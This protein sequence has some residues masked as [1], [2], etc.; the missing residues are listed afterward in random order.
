[1]A[2]RLKAIELACNIPTTIQTQ[3]VKC[4]TCA[5]LTRGL[6][7]LINRVCN[8]LLLLM[9]VAP[10]ALPQPNY[11]EFR[12][13]QACFMKSVRESVQWSKYTHASVLFPV[14]NYGGFARHA[15]IDD[16]RTRQDSY[17]AWHKGKTLHGLVSGKLGP[18]VGLGWYYGTFAEADA[19]QVAGSIIS[20]LWE[21][22]QGKRVQAGLALLGSL[23]LLTKE[24]PAILVADQMGY[25]ANIFGPIPT[26]FGGWGPPKSAYV[27]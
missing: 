13:Q 6:S 1:V 15:D 23:N 16:P 8:A 11:A 27:N 24:Y 19:G 4:A 14:G 2:I 9:G 5:T 22:A 26:S 17:S 7:V 25:T 20:S 12:E 18:G 21:G 3:F 10:L